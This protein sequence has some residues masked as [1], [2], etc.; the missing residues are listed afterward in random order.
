MHTTLHAIW[1]A[2]MLRAIVIFQFTAV[3]TVQML[4]QISSNGNTTTPL[5]FL[6]SM[7]IISLMEQ[8]IIGCILAMDWRMLMQ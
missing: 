3:M 4:T 2:V 1:C 7:G 5:R 8:L 6:I